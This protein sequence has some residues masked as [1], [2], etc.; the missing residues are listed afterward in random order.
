MTALRL[1]L[2]LLLLLTML[3]ARMMMTLTMRAGHTDWRSQALQ[4]RGG[5]RADNP[6]CFARGRAPDA[7]LHA[8][9]LCKQ[10]LPQQQR[11]SHRR[12]RLK[13]R[14]P[15]TNRRRIR[16]TVPPPTFSIAYIS[17]SVQQS[18]WKEAEVTESQNFMCFFSTRPF[19]CRMAAV[20]WEAEP[21][22]ADENDAVLKVRCV[23]GRFEV[24]NCGA[25]GCSFVACGER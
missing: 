22:E 24:L 20:N 5:W 10:S 17:P 6:E 25:A 15:C 7:Y 2:L 4:Q 13:L 14:R 1:L 21:A 11:Q 9:H 16:R 8:G 23:G 3:Q 19:V 12:H 18:K